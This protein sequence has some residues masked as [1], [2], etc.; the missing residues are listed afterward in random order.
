[1]SLA[2]GLPKRSPPHAA[3]PSPK[4][5]KPPSVPPPQWLIKAAGPPPA[6]DAKLEATVGTPLA[7]KGGARPHAVADKGSVLRNTSEQL[8][9]TKLLVPRQPST[10]PTEKRYAAGRG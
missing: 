4:R 9:N 6:K 1:M 8:P 7:V 3:D 2:P 10:P 5:P